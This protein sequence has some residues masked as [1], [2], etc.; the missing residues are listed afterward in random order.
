MTI[1]VG[2]IVRLKSGGPTMAVEGIDRP[3]GA[4]STSG[5]SVRTSW[6]EGTKLN[7]YSFPIEAVEL[8][9]CADRESTPETKTLSA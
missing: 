4:N 5:V 8:A 1:K 9:P 3:F 7:R 6:F 2:D